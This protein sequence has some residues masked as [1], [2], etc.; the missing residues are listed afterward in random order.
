MRIAPRDF[1]PV[2]HEADRWA[3]LTAAAARVADRAAA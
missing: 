2:T 1:T 3:M